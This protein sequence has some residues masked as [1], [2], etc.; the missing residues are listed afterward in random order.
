[1]SAT[2]K[3]L[4]VLGLLAAGV[5]TFYLSGL[6]EHLTWENVKARRDA[7]KAEVDAHPLPVAALF[8]VLYVAITGLSIPIGWVLTVTAGALF[9]LVGGAVFVSF[10]VMNCSRVREAR[11]PRLKARARRP[12]RF[13]ASESKPRRGCLNKICCWMPLSTTCGRG[14]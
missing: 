5:V 4:L 3:R 8:F 1:M 11:R 14:S 10:A 7:W 9:G 13:C 2:W 6:H 12:M